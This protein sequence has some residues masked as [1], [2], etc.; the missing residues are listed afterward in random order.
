[1]TLWT[2]S[3][4]TRATGGRSA[5]SWQ[6]TG[7]SIDSRSL[8]AG[9]LFVALSDRRDGHDFVAAA[10]AAGAAAA[11]VSRVPEN[12]PDGAP[13]LVVAD[14]LDGLRRLGAEG[15]NRNRGKVIAVT[16]SVGK[17]S[18]KEMLR[19]VL[20]RQGRTHAA[21][22]SHNNHW[23]VPLTLARMPRGSEFTVI[24]IGM[25]QPGEIA[26]L[27]GL[28]RPQVGMITEIAPAHLAAFNAID[29]IAEE[30]ASLFSGLQADG[31]AVLNA[32]SPAIEILEA[33]A[34]DAK[35]KIVHFG[36]GAG[37]SHR[38][39]E[40]QIVDTGTAM[41]IERHGMPHCVMLAAQGRHFAR[42]AL[43]V[44]AV[45][46][47]VGADPI[48]AAL[49]LRDW[50]PLAGRGNCE[51][52]VLDWEKPP[53]SLIDDAF[54]A[55]PVSMAAALEVLAA[56]NFAEQQP[57][58]RRIAVFSDMLELGDDAAT[59]H[60]AIAE[61][62]SVE[63]V[64]LMHCAGPLMRRLY[65]SLPAGKRGEWRETAAELAASARQLAAPGDVVLVK[66]SKGSRASLVADAFRGLG[67]IVR[68]A[69]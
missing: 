26:S 13:L 65:D 66:G 50:A 57:R 40:A 1:M 6:A 10:F 28:A 18:T 37:V 46:E 47:A 19:L 68:R 48:V 58:G 4:A 2:S 15:R 7:V 53:L 21:A 54:N 69:E 62:P 51:S 56:R 27:S 33:A 14:V 25:N 60:A 16:G 20:S 42:N 41:R 29:E 67:K 52:I 43:G 8:E 63:S 49:D 5:E 23:G 12:V 11:M 44:L 38:L 31:V 59:M 45:V 36:A 22:R 32:D 3:D 64:E 34:R 9:D 30:K 24:E 61:L 35:A 39:L 17:T 55:N